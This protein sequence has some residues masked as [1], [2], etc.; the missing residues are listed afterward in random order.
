MM[1]ESREMDA[2]RAA[3]ESVPDGDREF[4]VSMLIGWTRGYMAAAQGE[5]L[6]DGLGRAIEVARSI[7]ERRTQFL[8]MASGGM[9][10]NLA[11]RITL[12]GL[13]DL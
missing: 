7:V 5:G 10:P 9:D 2:M 4:V 3:I 11:A 1:S 12:S 6:E 13:R 8:N